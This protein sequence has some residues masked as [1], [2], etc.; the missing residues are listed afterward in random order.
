MDPEG[1]TMSQETPQHFPESEAELKQ[2]AAYVEENLW[3]KIERLNKKYR[4]IVDVLALFRY[5]T[6]PDVHWTKK[7]VV[8]AALL[9]FIVPVDAIPDLAPVIG[10]LDDMG[11]I[12]LAVRFLSN[13]LKAYYLEL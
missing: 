10:Y 1:K 4:W 3:E 12:A 7:T 2:Q 8:V 9:Y 11:V 6:D 5:M 13:Q